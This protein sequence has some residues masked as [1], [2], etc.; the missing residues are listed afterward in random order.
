MSHSKLTA[1][2]IETL[3]S[4]YRMDT[5]TTYLD[6]I[7][8]ETM[9]LDCLLTAP[10]G[11]M[12]PGELTGTLFVTGARI[13]AA[14]R[15]LEKKGYVSRRTDPEDRRSILVSLTDDGKKYIEGRRSHVVDSI[16]NLVYS[17][18]EGDSEELL[19]IIK[20]AEKVMM[21]EQPT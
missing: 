21:K 13:A 5:I 3:A 18:G 14:L 11:S 8:G 16:E 17:L 19:R 2:L 7:R 6:Y 15:T 12:R 10:S 9:V 1:E 4:L 20:R